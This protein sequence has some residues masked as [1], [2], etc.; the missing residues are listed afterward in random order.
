M[1]TNDYY[2]KSIK[3]TSLRMFGRFFKRKGLVGVN[4]TQSTIVKGKHLA[5]YCSVSLSDF[6]CVFGSI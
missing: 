4:L 3:Y 2:A 6:H 1:L 5:W